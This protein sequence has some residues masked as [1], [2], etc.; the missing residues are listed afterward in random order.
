VLWD[1]AAYSLAIDGDSLG[2]PN[3]AAIDAFA[4]DGTSGDFW[5]SFDTTLDL[6]G[7]VLR[8][9]DAADGVT[10]ALVFDASAAGVPQ[11]TDVD[12]VSMA[13]VPGGM[14]VLLSFDVGGTIGGI[15][16]A[17]EDVLRYDP[18]GDTWALE[19]DA[20]SVDAARGAAWQALRNKSSL[21]VGL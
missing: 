7:T 15:T 3:G 2:I 1:G 4:Y 16:F 13:P 18:V 21:R 8:D 17:D 5:L 10:L 9:A 19:L 11:G 6:S 14:H 12:A 20:S